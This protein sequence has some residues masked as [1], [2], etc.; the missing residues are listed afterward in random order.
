MAEWNKDLPVPLSSRA[1]TA[2]LGYGFLS[3]N[4]LTTLLTAE[5]IQ[6]MD[7]SLRD[8]AILRSVIKTKQLNDSNNMATDEDMT[9]D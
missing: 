2:V 8:K 3:S 7:L 6:S 9:D 4:E 5:D 1:L